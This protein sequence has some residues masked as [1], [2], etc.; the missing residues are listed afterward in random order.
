MAILITGAGG[1]VGTATVNALRQSRP[2]TSSIPTIVAGVLD[3]VK[4]RQS[5]P[6]RPDRFVT[7]DFANP[8]TFGPALAGVE[9]VLLVRPP[10]L[11]DVDRYFRPFIEAM[12]SAQIKQVVFLSL[13][14]VDKNSLTPHHKI[15]QLIRASGLYYTMLRPGFFM[16]NLSTTHR[17]EIRDRSEIYIP[18][19]Q[20]RTNFVDVADIGAV[21]ALTLLDPDAHRNRAYTLTGP[22]ALTYG[23]VAQILT[24]VL[25]RPIRYRNPSIPAFVWR[26]WRTDHEKIGFVL[27]MVALYTVAR[28]GQ[29]GTLTDELARLLG[30]PA[31]T[32]RQ[33]AEETKGVWQA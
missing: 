5:F 32:L 29:A 26:R 31:R 28:L 20:G 19:G 16:Q 25:G 10:Q 22:A 4:S 2:T 7:L 33:F 14:G 11:A 8:A 6:T 9:R 17:A 3:V 18:A 24:E 15:E 21:A 12:Q 30:R 27:I 13:E 1:N 23:E